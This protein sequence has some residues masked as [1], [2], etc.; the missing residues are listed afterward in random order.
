[1]QEGG[2]ASAGGPRTISSFPAGGA[3]GRRALLTGAP[4]PFHLSKQEV[5][6]GGEP[7]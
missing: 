4:G 5:Q 3:G 6:E 2:E 7:S 1:M